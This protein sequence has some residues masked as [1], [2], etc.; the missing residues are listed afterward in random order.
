M[1]GIKGGCPECGGA[2]SADW[3]EHCQGPEPEPEEPGR[4]E[5]IKKRKDIENIR[6]E[7]QA[8]ENALYDLNQEYD[9]KAGKINKKLR[10]LRRFCPHEN[11]SYNYGSSCND[12]GCSK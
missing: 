1:G 5:R 12:C 6:K 4:D 7:R 10:I 3:C 11:C 2:D 9:R 8:L